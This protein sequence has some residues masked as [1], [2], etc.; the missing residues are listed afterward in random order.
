M[1]SERLSRLEISNPV[2][3]SATSSRVSPS[4]KDGTI[5]SSTEDLLKNQQEQKLNQSQRASTELQGVER[6]QTKYASPENLQVPPMTTQITIANIEAQNG[7]TNS[8]SSAF[9]DT[10]SDISDITGPLPSNSTPASAFVIP[11]NEGITEE[12]INQVDMFYRSH[13][14]EV[15]VCRSLANLY[16]SAPKSKERTA[17]PNTQVLNKQPKDKKSKVSESPVP[18]PP[19]PSD[20]SKDEWEFSKTGIPV[21]VLDTGDHIREKRLR[22]I[23]AERGTG[24]TL[25]QDQFNHFTEYKTPHANFHTITL[26]T[27]STRLIGLSFDE[28]KAATEFSDAVRGFTSNADDDLLNLSKKKKKEKCKQK[29]KPPKK[30][31]ISQPVCFVHVT[32]LQKPDLVTGIF[33]PP[34]RGFA[35][36]RSGMSRAASESS[37]ISECSSNHSDH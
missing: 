28:D 37:G 11:V 16:V 30:V 12:N 18:T 32:K 22:I 34:P 14:T 4:F 26:S 7:K 3:Q 6:I 29:Y 10:S 19:D 8:S 33:P 9:S 1:S 13:K 21:L 27:D 31:D 2:L 36:T 17:S 23:L 20:F 24:F 15:K 5:Y 35:L 25:W